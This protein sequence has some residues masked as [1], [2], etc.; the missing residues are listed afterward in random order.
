VHE[1]QSVKREMKDGHK[2]SDKA[3]GKGKIST[4]LT[5]VVHVPGVLADGALGADVANLVALVA[6]LVGGD[7][8]A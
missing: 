6:A 4:L 2:G 1:G 7:G 8:D 3:A 5:S